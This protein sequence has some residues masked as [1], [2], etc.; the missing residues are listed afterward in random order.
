[1]KKCEKSIMIPLKKMV[2][3]FAMT[4]V[5]MGLHLSIA[6][7]IPQYY[8]FEGTATS[9]F[10][11]SGLI[12]SQFGVDFG[13][14]SAVN[15]TFLIDLDADGSYTQNDGTVVTHT[16]YTETD[17][18]T[19]SY[20][21]DFFYTDFV[22][23]HYISTENGFHNNPS[24]SGYQPSNISEYNFGLSGVNNYGGQDY[25]YIL[26]N[27]QS[28]YTKIHHFAYTPSSWTVGT[29]VFGI[30]QVWDGWG[31]NEKFS[32]ITTDLTL[33]SITAVPEPSTLLLLGIGLAGLRGMYLRR[34]IKK[35]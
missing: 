9:V 28:T 24:S 8:T 5:I 25:G 20:F 17:G 6:Q 2:R 30:A 32:E 16:D 22:S 33:T 12:A 29:A 19:Y 31:G 10:D 1:M 15:Y 21:N 35:Q 3:W 27:S 23:G 7:A 26:G 13:L 18:S 11:D 34:R 14:G 4:I